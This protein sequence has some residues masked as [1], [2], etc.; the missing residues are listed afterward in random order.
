V[1]GTCLLFGAS[2]LFLELVIRL[3]EPMARRGHGGRPCKGDRDHIV[4]RPSRVVGDLV[5]Q[6]AEEA[7]LTISDYVAAVLAR[8]HGVPEAAPLH[9][10]PSRRCCRW[11]RP[12][13]RGKGGPQKGTALY[14]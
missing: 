1:Q 4:T 9:R 8:A 5:R 6:R 10:A 3:S 2:R 13:K 14:R 7:G 12:P 11:A